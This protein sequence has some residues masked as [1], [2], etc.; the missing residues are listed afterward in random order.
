MAV[1]H[2]SV[3]GGIRHN[4]ALLATLFQVLTWPLSAS[5]LL[6]AYMGLCF[7]SRVVSAAAGVGLLLALAI[8][9]VVAIAWVRHANPSARHLSVPTTILANL[10]ALAAVAYPAL[11]LQASVAHGEKWALLGLAMAAYAG[12][13][14]GSG[15]VTSGGRSEP[16]DTPLPGEH[17]CSPDP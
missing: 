15:C 5:L 7:G 16:R 6:A 1:V 14:L 2:S 11:R 17:P 13:W 4:V 10:G 9:V 12:T 8:P 3:S